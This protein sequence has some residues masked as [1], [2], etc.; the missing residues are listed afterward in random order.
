MPREELFC[1][2]MFAFDHLEANTPQV[3][4]TDDIIAQKNEIVRRIVKRHIGNEA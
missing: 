1:R 2:A 3:R 4:V